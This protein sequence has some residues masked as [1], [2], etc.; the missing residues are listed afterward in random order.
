MKSKNPQIPQQPS[1]MP[2]IAPWKVRRMKSP[3]R[4]WTLC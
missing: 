3:R 4:L 2:N 1:K